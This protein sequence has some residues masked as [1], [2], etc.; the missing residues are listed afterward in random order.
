MDFRIFNWCSY[1]FD[2]KE[3]VGGLGFEGTWL[4]DIPGT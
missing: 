1:W 3:N 4:R 2:K